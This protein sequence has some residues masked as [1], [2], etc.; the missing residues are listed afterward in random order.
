MPTA[1]A[2]PA[3]RLTALDPSATSGKARQ[4]LDAVQ[5]KLGMAPNMMRTMAQSP[6]VLDGYL[7]FNTALAGG[8]LDAKTHEQLALAIAQTNDCAYCA[9]AHTALGKMAGLTP[10]QTVA[11]RRGQGTDPKTSAAINLARAIIEQR[12]AVSDDDLASAHAAGLG[13][14]EIAEVVAHVALNIFTNYFNRL[15]ATAID[16]PIVN[17]SAA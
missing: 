12:G 14:P 2:A 16:F 10:D 6:A 5:K 4:L 17:T 15:A 3:T 8:D 7:A 9:S 13:E 11:A 1:I